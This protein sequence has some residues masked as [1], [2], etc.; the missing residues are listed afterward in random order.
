MRDLSVLVIDQGT[1]LDR[2]DYNMEQ[3]GLLTAGW[4]QKG[5]RSGMG[6]VGCWQWAVGGESGAVGDGGRRPMMPPNMPSF[7]AQTPRPVR[8]PLPCPCFRRQ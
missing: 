6:A 8:L 5:G 3:V 4:V 2:I 7:C 1:I